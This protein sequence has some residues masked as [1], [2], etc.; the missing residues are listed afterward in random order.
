MGNLDIYGN[1]DCFEKKKYRIEFQG[2]QTRYVLI[3]SVAFKL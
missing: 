1:I 2:I 3:D